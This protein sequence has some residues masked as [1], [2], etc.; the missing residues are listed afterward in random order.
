[1]N[2]LGDRQLGRVQCDL[3]NLN[4]V[5]RPN[6]KTNGR[7]G[8]LARASAGTTEYT[9]RVAWHYERVPNHLHID[10]KVLA[11]W[12]RHHRLGTNDGCWRRRRWNLASGG[13]K[14]ASLLSGGSCRT[15]TKP[16]TGSLILS[17][18]IL[19]SHCFLLLLHIQQLN[20]ILHHYSTSFNKHLITMLKEK[21]KA[22][23]TD[24]D[25]ATDVMY[26]TSQVMKLENDNFTLL[27]SDDE[28]KTQKADLAEHQSI[29]SVI[30]WVK[31][32]FVINE[33]IESAIDSFNSLN[34]SLYITCKIVT[35]IL[36]NWTF[37][38]RFNIKL[39]Q[40]TSSL[41]KS[42]L[43]VHDILHNWIFRLHSNSD[44]RDILIMNYS[45]M[46]QLCTSYFEIMFF[47]YNLKNSKIKNLRQE[48]WMILLEFIFKSISAHTQ[49][50]LLEA[51][52]RQTFEPVQLSGSLTLKIILHLS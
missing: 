16:L 20:I 40:V 13:L 34:E 17:L 31:I 38:I 36:M 25:A 37:S 9:P 47:A 14:V 24:K 50:I 23:T 5:A 12:P 22:T 15:A 18:Y 10:T 7:N 1:M 11:R 42:C 48:E 3:L 52:A 39:H 51:T 45:N 35:K 28:K 30:F 41:F 43:S 2:C 26:H 32:V 27:I 46:S 6:G 21:S 8:P 29:K 4:M 19:Q 49:L 33:V 44:I